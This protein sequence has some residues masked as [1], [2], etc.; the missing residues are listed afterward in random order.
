MKQLPSWMVFAGAVLAAAGLVVWA[1]AH[2]R[3]ASAVRVAEFSAAL[4]DPRSEAVQSAVTL[5]WFGLGLLA[6]GVLVVLAGVTAM[7]VRKA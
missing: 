7:A 5:G 2:S 4:G 6:V 1:V 3:R